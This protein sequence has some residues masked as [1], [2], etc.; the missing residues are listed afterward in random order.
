MKAIL[1]SSHTGYAEGFFRKW[2]MKVVCRCRS[3]AG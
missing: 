1:H 2:M 3:L